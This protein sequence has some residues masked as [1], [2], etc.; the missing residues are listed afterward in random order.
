[1]VSIATE[2]DP[3][4]LEEWQ[5]SLESIQRRYGADRAAHLLG[6]LAA[7][8]REH[9]VGT[10]LAIQTPY[11]NTIAPSDQPRYPGSIELEHRIKSLVRWNALAMVV[12]A[13]REH[14]GIGGHIST[15]ASAATLFEVGFNHFFRAPSGGQPGD[16][17]YFQGHASPGVYVPAG[18]RPRMGGGRLAR[19]GLPVRRYRRPHDPRG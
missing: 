10:P 14:S 18:R 11:V 6:H 16:F 2:I 7:R 13:N 15:Y 17:V 4:E 1:V 5:E 8:A 19:E 3:A 12:R 9:G